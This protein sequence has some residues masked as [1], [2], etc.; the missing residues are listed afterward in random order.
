MTARVLVVEQG[1]TRA[2][3]ELESEG[4]TVV[5]SV[6]LRE[7]LAAC[8]LV[9]PDVVLVEGSAAHLPVREICTRLRGEL[10][11]PVAL[12]TSACGESDALAA[13][14]AGVDTVII[15][16]VGHHELVARLRALLR[17]FPSR[18]ISDD[19]IKVGPIVLSLARREIFVDGVEVH[20][21]R[22]EFDIAALLMREVGRV[23]PRQ[24]IVGE[25]WGTLRDTKSL[26]VQVGR[27]R[28]RLFAAEGRRRIVTV[29]GVGYRFLG[30]DDEA[31]VAFAAA[32]ADSPDAR[33]PI[34]LRVSEELQLEGASQPE[35]LEG[36][37]AV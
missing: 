4:F 8:E 32:T 26:D 20:V 13:F 2:A 29:R 18:A 25:L 19:I 10:S 31:R 11:A 36:S 23:V 22:R 28:A 33:G 5:T 1:S 17:R 7:A 14:A 30:D 21:P 35:S 16:P 6:H 24:R 15:E 37:A 9:Q 27:L 3:V 34:D 12:L